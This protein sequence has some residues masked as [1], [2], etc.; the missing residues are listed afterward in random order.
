MTTVTMPEYLY[1]DCTVLNWVDGDTLDMQARQ[2]TTIDPGFKIEAKLTIQYEGRFRLLFVDA[3]EKREPLG[4][5]ATAFVRMMMPEGSAVC[6][7][8][9]KDPDN[10]GRYLAD[11][12]VPE[13]PELT[14]S[15]QLISAGLG[16]PYRK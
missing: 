6:A 15:A 11:L 1:E 4:P 16:V 3:W 12:W 14:I 9:H 8:T 10:F 5:A 7:R 2:T 13:A